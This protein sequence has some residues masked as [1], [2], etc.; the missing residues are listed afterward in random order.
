[1]AVAAGISVHG[2]QEQGIPLNDAL[3]AV[4][5]SYYTGSRRHPHASHLNAHFNL[6]AK[7]TFNMDAAM[8]H[9]FGQADSPWVVLD[10]RS[11]KRRD[12]GVNT[13]DP[14]HGAHFLTMYHRA[15]GQVMITMPGLE[16]DDNLG[17]TLMDLQQM[18]LGGMRGQSRVLYNYAEEITKK[19]VAGVFVDAQGQ[20]LPMAADKPVIGA[21]SMGCTAAQMM[22]LADYKA[23]L[24]EPRPAHNGLL[25]RIAGNFAAITG[26]ERPDVDT[27][28]EKLDGATVNIRSQHSNVWNSVILPWIRQRELGK[29]FV[30]GVE[31]HAVVPA[32]RSIGTFHRVEMSV[33]SLNGNEEAKAYEGSA[34]IRPAQAG[35]HK[36]LLADIAQNN[37]NKPKSGL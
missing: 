36:G 28:A 34:F 37:A 5:A 31:G 20:P 29:N 24:I 1:M 9:A 2:D 21:H 18:A 35:E 8:E 10:H 16:S 22:T 7:N 17:D 14:M 23:V 27:V 33:P 32:D 15:T 6:R 12:A 4:Y 3:I 11:D 26:G 25:N 30:Y 13:T 19:M